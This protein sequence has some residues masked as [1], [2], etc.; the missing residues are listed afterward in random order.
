MT[1]IER[2][3]LPTSE[4]RASV[5]GE[6]SIEG[7]AALFNTPSEEL[8]GFR[9]VI[10]PHAFRNVLASSDTRA[11]FNH[12]VNFVLGRMSAGTLSLSEDERGLKA[13]IAPPDTQW[14]RDLMVSIRRGD[15]S[16]MSF[17]FKVAPGGQS[18][19]RVDGGIVRTIS[20]FASLLDVSPVT[21]PAYTDT[22]V[23][24]RSMQA[25]GAE[26]DETTREAVARVVTHSRAIAEGRLRLALLF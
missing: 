2:R 11:L 22:S 9:E 14:A 12:N 5:D 23:A 15:V 10:A 6:P 16:G 1:D 26:T 20:D 8:G 24:V 7:Y 3:F 13:N 19:R 17:G 21:Y 25:W 4:I 18:F